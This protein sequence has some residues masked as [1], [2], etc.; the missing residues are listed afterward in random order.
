MS[1][2]LRYNGKTAEEIL[3]SWKSEYDV[4]PDI[5]QKI[6]GGFLDG[7]RLGD[8]GR[9][10]GLRAILD[11]ATPEEA[12]DELIDIAKK[13]YFATVDWYRVSQKMLLGSQLVN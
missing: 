10:K 1:E 13:L 12:K 9:T 6:D 2:E 8:K 5:A 11:P 3:E 4:E 7:I